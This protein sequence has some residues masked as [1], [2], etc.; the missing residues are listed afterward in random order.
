LPDREI[1]DQFNLDYA[2][3]QRSER[4]F[5]STGAARN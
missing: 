3:N 4:C 1:A 2:Q 5:G